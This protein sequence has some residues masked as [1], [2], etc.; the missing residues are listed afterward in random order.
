MRK[1]QSQKKKIINIKLEEA[2][3][4]LDGRKDNIIRRLQR[5]IEEM[6][7]YPG[8][9]CDIAMT[10]KYVDELIEAARI[11]ERERCV[12]AIKVEIKFLEE[13]DWKVLDRDN[14]NATGKEKIDISNTIDARIRVLEKL[15]QKILSPNQDGL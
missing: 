8:S 14:H 4:L 12:D 2:K 13:A 11:V 6:G 10:L 1:I 5:I 3:K 7:Y 15:K 9:G